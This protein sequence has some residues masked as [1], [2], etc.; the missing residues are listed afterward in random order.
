MSCLWR[1]RFSLWDDVKCDQGPGYD[2]GL[3]RSRHDP[4]WSY[5]HQNSRGR[6]SIWSKKLHLPHIPTQG[7][8][9]QQLL[10]PEEPD[11]SLLSQRQLAHR[12][13]TTVWGC[14]Y[15]TIHHIMD[16]CL[17]NPFFIG[18]VSKNPLHIGS[19]SHWQEQRS[20]TR[21]STRTRRLEVLS[22]FLPRR[23]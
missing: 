13:P 20:T 16:P 19:M 14:R 12:L 15:A 7:K 21:G 3:Q 5:K 18:S 6:Q 17:K 10:G 23:V 9:V 22:H 11:W 2:H 4:S 1:R 8:G